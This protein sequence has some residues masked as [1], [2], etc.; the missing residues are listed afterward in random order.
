MSTYNITLVKAYA[1]YSHLV[2]VFSF[3]KQS[4]AKSKRSSVSKTGNNNN[5]KYNS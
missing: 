2:Y 3:M 1:N 4:F 5:K